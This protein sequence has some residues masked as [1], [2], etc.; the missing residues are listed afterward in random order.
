M[1]EWAGVILHPGP[2]VPMLTHGRQ[3][4]DAVARRIAFWWSRNNLA[5]IVA[6]TGISCWFLARQ[7]D[8]M[9]FC[10]KISKNFRMIYN[11]FIILSS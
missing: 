8:I 2:L 11:L 6:A 9:R 10:Q 4:Q 7:G 1:H 3:G 5:E